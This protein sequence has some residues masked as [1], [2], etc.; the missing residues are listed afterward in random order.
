[1]NALAHGRQILCI[2]HLPQIAVHADHHFGVE[3]QVRKGRTITNAKVLADEERIAELSRMLG[4][5]V[6]RREAERY[7]RRL[8]EDAQRG[9]R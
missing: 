5:A 1:L 4:G 3:K 9:S 6:A 7:A 8:V 2:T